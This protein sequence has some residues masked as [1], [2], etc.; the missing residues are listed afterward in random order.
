MVAVF[1]GVWRVLHDTGVLFCNLGDGY[2]D[3]QLLGMPWRLAL[4]LQADGWTLRSAITWCKLS[5][6]PESVTDRPTQATEMVFLFSKQ[7][8]YYYD[9]DAVRQP[10]ADRRVVSGVYTSSGGI[11]R[12]DYTAHHQGWV[13]GGG[14][15][16]GHREYNP[17]GANLRNYWLLGP[18]PQADEY[19]TACDTLFDGVQKRQIKQYDD[20]DGT[21]HRVCP[22]CSA[23]DQ[24]L[25]HYA[26]FPSEIP[27]RAILAGT[28]ERGQC[29][30]C[31]AGWTRQTETTQRLLQATNNR[32]KLSANAD[33]GWDHERWPR[34]TAERTTLA[35]AQSCT[36]PPY[37]PT[38]QLILDPFVGSGT[39]IL[40][41]LRLGRRAL[42]IEL[43]P[44]YARMAEAR[45]IRDAPLLNSQPEAVAVADE[46]VTWEQAGLPLEGMG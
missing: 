26:A 13:S 22:L 31:G 5:A 35:W 18:E 32:S 25:S 41:A 24:F 28:S 14:M 30:Q 9:A 33:N 40:Q 1:R 44:A 7:S 10:H 3:K 15:V 21:K 37:E 43:N 23:E 46:T 19:C 4:A 42:G 38:P 17:Y 8:R 2:R 27:R 11:N 45:I 16:I 12:P 6:M 34:T 36:C 39:T 20:A 29:P